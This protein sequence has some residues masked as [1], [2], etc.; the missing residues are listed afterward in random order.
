MHLGHLA[1][2]GAALV[3]T[4]AT[5]VE[6]RGRVSY[7][8]L[9]IWSDS[10]IAP[11][12]PIL[13]FCREHGRA[14]LGM[15]LAHSGRKGSAAVPWENQVGIKVDAG[16]WQTASPSDIAY[17]G[18]PA[19]AALNRAAL[20][21]M[22]DAF[23]VAAKRAHQA[24]FDVLE[25]HNAHGYLLHSFLTPF[26]NART[27][28]YGGSIENRMR[29]PLEVFTS[30]RDAWPAEKPLGVRLSATDWAPGGWTIEDT[31]ELA[32]RLKASGCDYI[33]ASSG[34]STPLQKIPIG[35]GYQVPLAEKVRREAGIPTVAVGLIT[36]ARQAE[37]ILAK[38]P[39][40]LVAIGRAMLYNP[41]WAW[42]AA[43]ELGE[44][45]Y[46]PPQYERSHPSML[47]D[48]F[49]KPA[50]EKALAS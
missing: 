11:L 32:K 39:A 42:H 15:Q 6:P 20:K 5:A 4:E 21:A 13:E 24:G 1:I 29:F 33:C 30:V 49:L 44:E 17:P 22:R 12:R 50:R 19:P 37:D 46:F 25:I 9:G 18:R 23:G 34:G 40:D 36:Q 43:A 28:E 48:D 35:P 27:D 7:R 2:S 47:K 45:A 14:K 8:C 16:G 3:Y 31:V 38:G 26:A 10:H 41:R